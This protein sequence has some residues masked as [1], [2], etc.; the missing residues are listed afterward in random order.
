M[1]GESQVCPRVYLSRCVRS[2]SGR[3][4][5]FTPALKSSLHNTSLC[6]RRQEGPS[7][8]APEKHWA[9]AVAALR[10][11]RRPKEFMEH[12]E[13]SI[14]LSARAAQSWAGSQGRHPRER[15]S[16]TRSAA[17]RRSAGAR[18]AW[19]RLLVTS[20]KPGSA[21][22]AERRSP[23]EGWWSLAP[24]RAGLHCGGR[25]RWGKQTHNSGPSTVQGPLST[26]NPSDHRTS[27]AKARRRPARRAAPGC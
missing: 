25:V 19:R 12:M 27:C 13:V 14:Q 5:P 10:F 3:G 26:G 24:G 9:C 23:Q 1:S 21:L 15:P 6:L 8:N 4:G 16:G 20:A 18:A 7:P 11:L 22:Q 17:G 2:C